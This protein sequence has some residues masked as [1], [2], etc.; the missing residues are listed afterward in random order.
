MWRNFIHSI[1]G[2]TL[3]ESLIEEFKLFYSQNRSPTIVFLLK[4]DKLHHCVDILQQCSFA[5]FEDFHFLPDIAPFEFHFVD[6]PEKINFGVVGLQVM[7][8]THKF[9]GFSWISGNVEQRHHK[10]KSS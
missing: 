3:N 4:L 8:V 9:G 7:H 1:I 6:F 10:F 5:Y 2:S